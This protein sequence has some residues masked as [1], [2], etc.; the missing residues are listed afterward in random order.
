LDSAGA[1]GGQFAGDRLAVGRWAVPHRHPLLP[2]AVSAEE[3]R[4]YLLRVEDSRGFNTPVQFVSESYL[5]QR[6]Q[7]ISLALGVYFGLA[8]LTVVS[9]GASA[10]SLRDSGHAYVALSVALTGLAQAADTGIGG[11]HLWPSLAAWNDMAPSTLTV[12]AAGATVRCYLSIVSIRERAPRGYRSIRLLCA[13]S[14]PAGLLTIAVE[15]IARPMI[16][17]TYTVLALAAALACS[18]WA[19]RRGDRHGMTLLLASAPLAAAVALNLVASLGFVQSTSW[20]THSAQAGTAVLWPALLA[21]LALLSRQRRENARRVQRLDRV[22]PVTGLVNDLEFAHQLHRMM[23]RSQRLKYQSMVLVVHV[24]N[25]KALL[26]DFDPRF[27]EELP[28]RVANRLL[29]VARDIDT[30]GRLGEHRF[31]VLIEGPLSVDEAAEFA[32]RVIARCLMPF[33]NKPTGWVPQVKVAQT[34]VPHD[35]LPPGILLERLDRLLGTTTGDP[36]RAVITLAPGPPLQRGA[37]WGAKDATPGKL[38]DRE[39]D[40]CGPVR[41]PQ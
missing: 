21:V 41:P 38:V 31:G 33:R 12:L 29:T 3:P 25:A 10:V 28:V 37:E 39:R 34:V 27:S 19:A 1:W 23:V 13:L 20:V 32:P 30:V 14:L 5:N 9:A 22:D 7:R 8:V 35:G 18:G 2:V 16:A 24:T 40:R 17:G 6:E 4:K 11:L 15:P 26:R 36:K